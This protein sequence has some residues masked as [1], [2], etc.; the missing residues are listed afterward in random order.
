MNRRRQTDSNLSLDVDSLPR[1]NLRMTQSPPPEPDL[2]AYRR[3]DPACNMSRFYVLSLEPTLFG[4]I[5]VVRHWGRI[6]TLGRQKSTFHESLDAARLVLQRHAGKKR[7]R[8]Y[9]GA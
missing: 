9:V 1:Q 2:Q 6:G 8:G 4:E 5:A 7:R 3:I